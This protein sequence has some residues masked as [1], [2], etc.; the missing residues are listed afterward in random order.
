MAT[1]AEIKGKTLVITLDIQEPSPSAMRAYH[2]NTG[3][4]R[5]GRN[6][7][8]LGEWLEHD[9]PIVPCERGLHASEHPF[10]ALQYAP[11]TTL[12]MV[13]LEGEL[14]TH[15]NPVDKLCGRRRC[16]IASIDAAALLREFARWC[17]QQ[18]L[19]LWDA[20]D[21]VKEFLKTGREDLM[22]AACAA[23]CAAVGAAARD[24]ARAAAW[25]ASWAAARAAARNSQASFVLGRYHV[26]NG[27][28][29]ERRED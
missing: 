12:D 8:P 28:L 25:A 29:E 7:P 5:D 26:I 6:L 27:S 9:G 19:P 10:D 24:A 13:D 16:R 14:V 2:F 23:A 4:L 3:R 15:G 21:V 18:V 11:G 22:A 17:A 20:P 1:T